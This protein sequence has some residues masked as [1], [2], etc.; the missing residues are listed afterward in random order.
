MNGFG[1]LVSTARPTLGVAAAEGE[2]QVIMLPGWEKIYAAQQ[3]AAANGLRRP[4]ARKGQLPL[5]IGAGAI[6]VL[7]L[8]YL[9][10]SKNKGR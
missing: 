10:T 8:G 2:P 9:F 7:V 5:V 1:Q 3:V 4:K 6:I